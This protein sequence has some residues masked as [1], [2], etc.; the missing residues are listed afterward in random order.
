MVY[1]HADSEIN[2]LPDFKGKRVT[3]IITAILGL[4]KGLG[5]QV[6]AEGIETRAQFQFLREHGCEFGQGYLMSRPVPA[7]AL[8]AMLEAPARVSHG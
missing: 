7:D 1:R 3:Q 2:A 8:I 5:L 6:I 4:A